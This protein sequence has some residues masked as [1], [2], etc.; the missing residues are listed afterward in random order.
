MADETRDSVNTETSTA[1]TTAPV[2][3][4]KKLRAPRGSKSAATIETDETTADPAAAVPSKRAKATRAKKTKPSGAD[5]KRVKQTRKS[6]ASAAFP[7]AIAAPVTAS[8]EMAD[9]LQLEEENQKLRKQL[10]EKL[11]T[12][13]ADLRKRLGVS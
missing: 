13:N 7:N 4:P 9:L 8:D 1:E 11:R 10:A 3:E 2:A 5:A 6:R 12:E